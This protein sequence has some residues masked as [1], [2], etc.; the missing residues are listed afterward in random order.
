MGR[1]LML[2]IAVKMLEDVTC[3]WMNWPLTSLHSPAPDAPDAPD[4]PALTAATQQQSSRRRVT[5]PHVRSQEV[6]L[7]YPQL[8]ECGGWGFW[9]GSAEGWGGARHNYCPGWGVSVVVQMGR[10][11]WC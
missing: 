6:I 2:H 8:G 11:Y 10:R 5:V 1:E 3:N 7:S 4:S 9:R